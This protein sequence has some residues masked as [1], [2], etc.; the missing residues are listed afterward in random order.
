[1]KNKQSMVTE[2]AMTKTVKILFVVL[3]MVISICILSVKVPETKYVEY[4]IENLDGS[5][6]R[7]MT[8]SVGC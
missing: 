6:E 4:T 7:V 1:M 8:F 3:L 2:E 5:R